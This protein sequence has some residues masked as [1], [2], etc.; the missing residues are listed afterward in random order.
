MFILTD[1]PAFYDFMI[2]QYK[3]DKNGRKSKLSKSLN[4]T[5]FENYTSS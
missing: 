5:D 2:Q 1:P 4:E 3:V